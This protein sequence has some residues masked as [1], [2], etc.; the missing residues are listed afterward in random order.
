[1][2]DVREALMVGR[3]SD[4][5]TVRRPLSPH[6]QVYKPQI[7]ST[8]SI[9]HRFTGIALSVGT[10]LLVWWL[11]AAATS[12]AAYASV[13]GFIRS[14]VGYLLLFG[15]TAALWYHFCSGIRHLFWDVGYGFELPTVHAT[16]KAVLVATVVLTLL[17][18]VVGL[19]TL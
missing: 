11:V 3:T 10:L 17:T 5:R 15:W 19:A 6:L 12:D 2:T 7:T 18:W 4:G 9:F 13:S 1:M 16:G 8:L 14:P